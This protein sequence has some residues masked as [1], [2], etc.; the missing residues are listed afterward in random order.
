YGSSPDVPRRLSEPEMSSEVKDILVGQLW[1]EA[2]VT[3]LLL[4]PSVMSTHT[5]TNTGGGS[6]CS[7]H[8]LRPESLEGLYHE[9]SSRGRG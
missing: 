2:G 7:R 4:E 1:G 9:R 6:C 5:P 3:L 8:V